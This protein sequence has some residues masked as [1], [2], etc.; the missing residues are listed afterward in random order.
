M[1]HR[2]ITFQYDL[3]KNKVAPGRIVCLMT[4]NGTSLEKESILLK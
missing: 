3:K 2:L 1:I 4:Y